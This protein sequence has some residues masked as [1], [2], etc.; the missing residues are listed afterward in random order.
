MDGQNTED[1]VRNDLQ[2]PTGLTIDFTID[3]LFWVDNK[4]HIIEC[5]DLDGRNRRSV[6]TRDVKNPFAIAVFEEKVY[7]SDPISKI[8][9]SANKFTGSDRKI[10]I[11]HE[12]ITSYIPQGIFVEHPLVQPN[13][14]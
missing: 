4:R 14:K 10:L 3:K 12:N 7:W 5:S 11:R 2:S 13:G 9:T 8:V 6:I 1:V